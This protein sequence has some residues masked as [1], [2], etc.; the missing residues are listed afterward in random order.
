MWG[1][2]VAACLPVFVLVAVVMMTEQ[3][4]R[5]DFKHISQAARL[6]SPQHS[7]FSDCTVIGYLLWK[8]LF[9]VPYYKTRKK[10]SSVYLLNWQKM[11]LL[12]CLQNGN[13]PWRPWA[14][15]I[16]INGMYYTRFII[17]LLLGL[18]PDTAQIAY[19]PEV[20]TIP[21]V[22]P[23]SCDSISSLCVQT[24]LCF[25]LVTEPSIKTFE[26]L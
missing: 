1:K 18:F 21:T 14:T 6:Q 23:H 26:K 25:I 9:L 17:S 3:K 19:G 24:V 5:A 16:G 7:T 12:Y 13:T 11:F 15:N 20:S 8:R 10:V 22:H 4:T 2:N